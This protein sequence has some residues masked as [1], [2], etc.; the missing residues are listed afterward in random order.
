M[1][2]LAEA[3]TTIVVI[4]VQVHTLTAQIH[5]ITYRETVILFYIIKFMHHT[6]LHSQ[7]HIIDIIISKVYWM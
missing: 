7:L 1:Y 6:T 2:L 5:R 3:T 4:L